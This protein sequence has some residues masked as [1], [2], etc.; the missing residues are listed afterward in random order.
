MAVHRKV[1]VSHEHIHVAMKTLIF[2]YFSE[3]LCQMLF[4]INKINLF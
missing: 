3:K 1:K 4:E 2:E